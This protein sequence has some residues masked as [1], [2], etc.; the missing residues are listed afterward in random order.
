MITA[1]TVYGQKKKKKHHSKQWCPE[2]QNLR[3]NKE[4]NFLASFWR[5]EW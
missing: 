4:E 2:T 5:E 3:K 1:E